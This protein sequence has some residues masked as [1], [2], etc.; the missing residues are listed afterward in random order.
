MH[1]PSTHHLIVVGEGERV[2]EYGESRSHGLDLI[3]SCT[4]H[5]YVSLFRSATQ[6]TSIYL[7][8][9]A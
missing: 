6:L 1:T 5:N 7:F 8:A 9:R 3:I 2:Y 4:K